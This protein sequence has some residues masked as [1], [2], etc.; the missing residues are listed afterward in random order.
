MKIELQY[1]NPGIGAGSDELS[2]VVLA[3]FG[4]MPRKKDAKAGFHKLLLELDDRKKKATNEKKPELAVINVE[5]MGSV[6]GIKRQTMY[7]YLRRWVSLQIIK[8]T[9]LV[10]NGAVITGYELNGFNLENAFKKAE[11]IIH[12]HMDKSFKIIKE[13]ENEI[14]KDKLRKN[15]DENSEEIKENIPQSAQIN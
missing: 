11:S 14:K 1:M 3:R 2:K 13:L 15:K 12:D 7:D 5:E 8:K 10:N 4:L 6:S 9:S